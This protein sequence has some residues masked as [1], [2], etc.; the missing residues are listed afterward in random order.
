MTQFQPSRTPLSGPDDWI[1][2]AVSYWS[3]QGLTG[4]LRTAA[5]ELAPETTAAVTSWSH[6]RDLDRERADREA[7]LRKLAWGAVALTAASIAWKAWK[8]R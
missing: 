7:M 8:R 5:E 1:A 3:K 2:T 4:G 6:Q